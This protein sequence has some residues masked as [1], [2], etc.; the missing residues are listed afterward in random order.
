VKIKSEEEAMVKVMLGSSDGG[1]S[2]SVDSGK[3]VLYAWMDAPVATIIYAESET[4]E[5]L[6]K[7]MEKLPL[8]QRKWKPLR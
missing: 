6:F 1:P 2:I 5:G 7:E 8:D 4:I 3:F